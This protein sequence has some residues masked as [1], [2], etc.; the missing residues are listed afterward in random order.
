[1]P[2]KKIS[3][4]P[5]KSSLGKPTAE[6]YEPGDDVSFRG[7]REA[8]T[9]ALFEEDLESIRGAIGLIIRK[10]G[11]REVT[12]ATGLPKSTLYRMTEPSSNP[13]L[14]N[15]CRVL[16]YISALEAEEAA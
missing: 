15:V 5:A 4:K 14:E 2:K 11:Y 1:M 12:K 16:S 10:S 13:T 8:V 9:E 7:I 3:R 6:P